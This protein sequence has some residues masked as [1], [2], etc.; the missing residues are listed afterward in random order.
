MSVQVLKEAPVLQQV[1]R[2]TELH[3]DSVEKLFALLGYRH[4]FM[5]LLGFSSLPEQGQS[6]NEFQR[7][8]SAK[9]N[10]VPKQLRYLDE[11]TRFAR[12][13]WGQIVRTAERYFEKGFYETEGE[14]LQSCRQSGHL[15]DLKPISEAMMR[16]NEARP[17]V[18]I[19]EFPT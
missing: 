8:L 3:A 9:Q 11:V 18:S 1:F 14:Y 6:S 16:I 2:L 15:I 10:S 7:I 12:W 17:V 5:A 4:E 19:E 13:P